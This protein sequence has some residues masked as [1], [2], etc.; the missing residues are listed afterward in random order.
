MFDAI[1]KAKS[2]YDYVQETDTGIVIFT[3]NNSTSTYYKFQFT[4]YYG[5][6][7]S[8]SEVEE[9]INNFAYTHVYDGTGDLIKNSYYSIQG[10]PDAYTLEP[11]GGGYFAKFSYAFEGY[12]SSY[13]KA[14]LTSAQMKFSSTSDNNA[15]IF[16]AVVTP[17]QTIEVGIMTGRGFDGKWMVYKSDPVDNFVVIYPNQVAATATLSS[18]GVYTFSNDVELKLIV[19]DGGAR[20]IISSSILND[21]EVNAQ[22]SSFSTT[23][24]PLAF[25]HMVSYVPVE[26]DDMR[27]GAYLKNVSLSNCKLYKNTTLTGTSYN[28]YA[29]STGSVNFAY[30]YNEDVITYTKTNSTKE[31]INIDYS[32]SYR[33]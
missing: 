2:S 11:H 32:V 8:A 29:D 30:V 20:G 21:Y 19:T 1:G 15:Y 6:T 14:N 4:K 25:F 17:T 23:A 26:C 12:K 33:E 5:T 16:Q 10:T 27:N 24:S 18:N 13:M 7:T 9:W 3:K 31:T 28:F 22:G